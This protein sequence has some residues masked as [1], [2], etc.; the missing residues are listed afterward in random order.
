MEQIG[1]SNKTEISDIF[2]EKIKETD[3]EGFVTSQHTS[4][5]VSSPYNEEE[6][7]K[8]NIP[9]TKALSPLRNIPKE[10]VLIFQLVLCLIIAAAAFTVK[11]VGGDIYSN[12]KEFYFQ[13]LDNSIIIDL[14]NSFNNDFVNNYF[15][16][17]K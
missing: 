1:Y 3:S 17:E 9:K 11:T 16:N 14:N 2:C 15:I 4:F 12:I 13:N 6:Q 8:I 5:S 7:L 10:P